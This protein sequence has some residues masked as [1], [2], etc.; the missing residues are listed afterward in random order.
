MLYWAW[1]EGNFEEAEKHRLIAI[2][3]EPLSTIDLS[4]LARTLHTAGRF[5]EALAYAE[6]A[7]EIDSNS[8]LGQRLTGL[9]YLALR[10]Y[11][12]AI[13]TFQFLIKISERHQHAVDSLIWVYCSQGIYEKAGVLINEM[14]T[15]SKTEFIGGAHYG[16]SLAYFGKLDVA[17]EY[18]NKACNDLDTMLLTFKYS[19]Y[20]PD[21]LRNDARFQNILARVGFPK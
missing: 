4:D 5:E 15:R 3:S 20:V 12:E 17:F 9:C 21:V 1:V 8:F 2:K 11:E 10:R 6:K 7:I 16:I 13:E 14:E 19:P 18:L